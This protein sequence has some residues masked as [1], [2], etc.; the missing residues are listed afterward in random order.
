MSYIGY[1]LAHANAFNP[2]VIGTFLCRTLCTGTIYLCAA[3][4]SAAHIIAAFYFS[5]YTRRVH[6]MFA[7]PHWLHKQH[8]DPRHSY[9]A[10]LLATLRKFH[11]QSVGLPVWNIL[12]VALIALT[13]WLPDASAQCQLQKITAV[14]GGQLDLFGNA[15][16]IDGDTALIGAWSDDDACPGDI[17]CNSG[18]AYIFEKLSGVWTQTAKLTADDGVRGDFFGVSVAISGDT[19]II[20]ANGDDDICPSDS[21]CESGSAYVFEKVAG[22]WTQTTKLTADDGERDDRFGISVAVSGDTAVIG[23]VYDDDQGNNSGAAYVFEKIAGIWTNTTKLIASNGTS[24]DFFGISVAVSG[25]TALIGA[26]RTD[27][28]CVDSL[29]CDSGSAYVFEKITGIWTQKSIFSGSRGDEFGIS[30]ALSDDIAVIGAW[31][32]DD[33]CPDDYDCE[34]GSASV[35]EKISGVWRRTSKLTAADGRKRDFFGISVAVSG[36]TAIIGA[37]HDD[38]ACSGDSRCESG[39]AYIFKKIFGV[40]TQTAKITADDEASHDEFG[41]SVAISRDMTLIGASRNDDVCPNNS[42]CNSGA[43]YFFAL[44]PDCNNNGVPDACDIRDDTSDDVNENGVPDDCELLVTLDIRPGGCPNPLNVKSKGVVPMAIVGSESFDVTEIDIESLVLSRADGIGGVVA[45][46]LGPL[47]HGA[48][49]EDVATLFAGELCA[50]HEL[51]GDGI[52]DLTL[53]F[54]TSDL[55]EVLELDSLP[56]QAVVTLTLSGSLYDGT[57]FAA[58]DCMTI[59]SDVLPPRGLR[60]INKLQRQIPSLPI[61]GG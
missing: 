46:F 13:V 25:D 24:H 43:S 34:S 39:S 47:G 17:H 48:M 11:N 21:L 31:F 54:S 38:D 15:V 45:P 22:V 36:D 55:V 23:A 19:V 28:P 42:A 60:S 14:D 26:S 40:W 6:T 44:G 10:H 29:T 1:A 32:D 35:F 52:D 8:S 58:S 27:S 49:I 57:A 20:G 18:S 41:S 12:L 5:S 16:A 3:I 53:K 2:V 9:L 33:A 61:T 7:T 56:R 51:L 50:C 37:F 30:V 59:V 4:L